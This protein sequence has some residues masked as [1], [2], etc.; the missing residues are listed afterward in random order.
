MIVYLRVF[1]RFDATKGGVLEMRRHEISGQTILNYEFIGNGSSDGGTWEWVMG[2]NRVEAHLTSNIRNA[3]AAILQSTN[4][5]QINP[6]PEPWF[7]DAKESEGNTL[8][9][10]MANSRTETCDWFVKK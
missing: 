3:K 6:P 7:A 1:S 10:F 5:G 8:L 4:W 2:A 9:Y